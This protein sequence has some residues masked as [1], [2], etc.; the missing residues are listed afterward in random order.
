MPLVMPKS[1]MAH[2]EPQ[3]GFIPHAGATFYF[4]RMEGEIG[5]FIALTGLP[6]M[7]ADAIVANC[8]ERVL[9]TQ[10]NFVSS[11]SNVFR[12]NDFGYNRGYAYD[13]D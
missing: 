8:A 10:K 3:F 7:R 11:V 6:L 9:I 4:S 2:N 12:Q 5:A 1:M 13:N